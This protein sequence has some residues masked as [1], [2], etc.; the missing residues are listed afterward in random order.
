MYLKQS[1]PD[2]NTTTMKRLLEIRTCR[3]MHGTM[4]RPI[5]G[6]YM[7]AGMRDIWTNCGR[8]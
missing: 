4:T 1:Q 8:I 5:C 6:Q 3:L 2:P 7:P